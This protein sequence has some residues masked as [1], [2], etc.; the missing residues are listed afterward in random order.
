MASRKIKHNLDRSGKKAQGEAQ[1]SMSQSS[2]EKFELMKKT[3]SRL[4]ERM[5]VEN[6]P[7]TTDQ[8]DSQPRNKN[9]RRAPVP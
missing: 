9:F 6:K 8:N 3:I 5:S 2:D 4:M 7:T 1:P